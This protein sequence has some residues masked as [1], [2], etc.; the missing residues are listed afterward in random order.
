M[1]DKNIEQ[2]IN[3]L[4][5][6]IKETL[7]SME[8]VSNWIVKTN[9]EIME[10]EEQLQLEEIEIRLT[11]DFKAVGCKNKE[12]RE[13]YIMSIPEYRELYLQKRDLE[14]ALSE[15]RHRYG[16]DER[17]LKMLNR[18]YDRLVNLERLNIKN[19]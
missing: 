15:Y 16:V 5:Q 6:K 18:I 2:E 13:M 10:V 3:E 7:E 14:I 12:E 4:E 9:I 11:T 8:I 1:I 19:G 17:H